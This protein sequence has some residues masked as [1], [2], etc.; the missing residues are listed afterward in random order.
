MMCAALETWQPLQV[1][2]LCPLQPMS[3][4]TC[5]KAVQLVRGSQVCFDFFPKCKTE[6]KMHLLKH[7]FYVS[8]FP[9][10]LCG[11]VTCAPMTHIKVSSKDIVFEHCLLLKLC[12]TVDGMKVFTP[13]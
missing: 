9:P 1:S 8:G 2:G 10:S 13:K 11:C 12:R 6:K 3:F 7:V 5:Y 4:M